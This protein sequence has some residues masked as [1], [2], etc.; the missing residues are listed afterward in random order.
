[1][2]VPIQNKLAKSCKL[3]GFVLLVPFACWCLGVGNALGSELLLELSD[4]TARSRC[5]L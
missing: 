3:D 1:M 2:Q 5:G 4:G